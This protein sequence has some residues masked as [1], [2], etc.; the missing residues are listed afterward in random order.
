M[1]QHNAAP[2]SYRGVL[3]GLRITE[4][5]RKKERLRGSLPATMLARKK[6][7]HSGEAERSGLGKNRGALP[8]AIQHNTPTRSS[9][10]PQLRR[11]IPPTAIQ[12]N[13]P[14]NGDES[15]FKQ[16]KRFS[17]KFS[18]LGTPAKPNRGVLRKALL[19]SF[20][21]LGWMST[22]SKLGSMHTRTEGRVTVW[23]SEFTT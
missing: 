1:R 12:H 3:E 19:C 7:K 9:S 16:C 6:A 18:A 14:R 22:A 4:R 8:T 5:K 20:T 11:G 17:Y 2:H 13:T 23:G 21:L 10:Q 15:D